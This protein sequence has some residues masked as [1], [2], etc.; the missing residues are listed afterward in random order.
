[1]RSIPIRTAG[2]SIEALGYGT[3]GKLYN[4]LYV[5]QLQKNLISVSH[6]CKDLNC[7]FYQD[8]EKCICIDKTSRKILHECP[9]RDGLYYFQNL[10]RLGIYLLST[11]PEVTVSGERSEQIQA[12]IAGTTGSNGNPG[13]RS[14]GI[15]Y[16]RCT[17][18]GLM[19]YSRTERLILTGIW[20]GYSFD[21][22]LLRNFFL[23]Q[24]GCMCANE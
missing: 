17:S 12:Y 5:P 13:G 1:M 3:V 24:V 8:E 7:F 15:A 22:V 20:S 16:V 4:C 2:K 9:L 23:C 11:A 21:M 6:V 14:T 10:E 19:P 18:R